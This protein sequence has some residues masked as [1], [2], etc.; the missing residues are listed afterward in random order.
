VIITNKKEGVLDTKAELVKFYD[1]LPVALEFNKV[2]E[3]DF[4]KLSN[5]SIRKVYISFYF[6]FL[7]IS[8]GLGYN[9]ITWFIF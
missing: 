8:L 4:Y 1:S 7:M 2:D 3:S 6:L 9:H 5:Y